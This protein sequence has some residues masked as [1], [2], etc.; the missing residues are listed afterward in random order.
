MN[1]PAIWPSWPVVLMNSR[2]LSLCPSASQVCSPAITN[3]AAALNSSFKMTWNNLVGSPVGPAFCLVVTRQCDSSGS[4]GIAL[5]LTLRGS[6]WCCVFLSR[7]PLL[8]SPHTALITS[9]KSNWMYSLFYPEKSPWTSAVG[10]KTEER[11][12]SLL[13]VCFAWNAFSLLQLNV[14]FVFIRSPSFWDSPA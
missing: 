8:H 14:T 10:M 12:S 1:L 11:G 6:C 9:S 2:C 3:S 5:I 4:S 7:R 13:P